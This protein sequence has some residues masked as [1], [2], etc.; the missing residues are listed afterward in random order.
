[1]ATE[2]PPQIR[3]KKPKERDGLHPRF[4]FIGAS[5]TDLLA[6]GNPPTELTA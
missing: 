5:G 2:R 6:D 1:M 4:A 3:Q